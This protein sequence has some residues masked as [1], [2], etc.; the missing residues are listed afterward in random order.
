MASAPTDELFNCPS[1]MQRQVVPASSVFQM[2]PATA[3]K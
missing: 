3:P 1:E 2:P